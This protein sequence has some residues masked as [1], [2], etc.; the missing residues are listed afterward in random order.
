MKVHLTTFNA[1]YIHTSMAL[2][3]LYVVN[4]DRFDL[5]FSEYTIKES[6]SVVADNILEGGYD[7]VGISVSIWNVKQSRELAKILKE[8]NPDII[9]I[10]GGPEVSYEP[11]FFINNWDVD[12][13]VSGEGEFVLGQLLDALQ[14]GNNL[15]I[16]SVSSKYNISY[17]TAQADITELIKFPSPYRLE[18]DNNERRNRITYFETSRGCPYS[19]QYCLS[20]LEKGVRYF[21]GEYIVE[22]L[23]YLIDSDVKQIKFLDR[24]FNLNKKHT[25]TV[26]DFLIEN[27][28]PG[29]NCQFEIYADLLNDE[30]IEYLNSKVPKNY[31]RFEIGI[32]STHE[33][34][35]VA[36]K[37]NQNFSL[38]SSNI[39]KIMKGDV[40][41][42]HLDLIA[43]LPFETFDRFR[44]SFNDVFRLRAKEVQLGFL[45][46]LRGTNLRRDALIY[47]YKFYNEAPYEIISGNDISEVE[48]ERIRDV[49]EALDK[50]WNSGRFASTMN[51]L[52]E[53]P[54]FDKYFDFFDEMGHYYKVKNLPRMGYQLED[55][56]NYLDQFLKSKGID[57]C[58]FLR[59]DYYSNFKIRPTGYWSDDISKAE[60]KKLLYTIG[61]DKDFLSK[62][63]L[64]RKIIEK[65]T[66]INPLKDGG[67]LLTIF[68]GN[69]K[70]ELVYF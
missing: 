51:F 36:V 22:N 41:D 42:L 63:N 23:K 8:Q 38:L 19:C 52:F 37:R 32:Q 14:K 39:E 66:A 20:S 48:L 18:F 3:W 24:T 49:E 4:K 16:D 26:F 1:K 2:R 54:Y 61:Q 59:E 7:V 6:V 9:I 28:R 62:H 21:P 13:V 65:Q 53:G 46:L 27:H 57:A 29:L 70:Q 45:K 12:Y 11:Q 34:T 30:T 60:R 17:K 44:K 31:F 68:F 33:P 40:I 25:M 47:G 67:Y 58:D 55:L 43:G 15:N 64:T 35:N 10:T 5:S 56:F 50:F 69:K